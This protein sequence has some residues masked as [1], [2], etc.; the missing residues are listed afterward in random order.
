M[1]Y[2]VQRWQ[3]NRLFWFFSALALRVG[4][5]QMYLFVQWAF[6]VYCPTTE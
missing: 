5:N 1:F 4:K 6:F 3:K 2:L